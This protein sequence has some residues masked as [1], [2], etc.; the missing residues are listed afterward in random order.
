MSGPTETAVIYDH[1]ASSTYI[2]TT[3]PHARRSP[4]IETNDE[5][6]A[7]GLIH[8]DEISKTGEMVVI[9]LC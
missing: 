7:S 1:G 2:K 5:E 6:N 3:S 8:C 9:F 4:W